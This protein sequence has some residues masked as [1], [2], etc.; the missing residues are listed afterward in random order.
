MTVKM[1]GKVNF[2]HNSYG[3]VIHPYTT[4]GEGVKIYHNVTIGRGNIWEDS[5]QLEGFE[6]KNYAVL[7]AGAKVI[8]S[9]GK[10]TIGEGTII[11]ANAVLTCS[12]GDYEIWAGVPAVRIGFR[13][14]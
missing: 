8:C 7:C 14:H 1:A 4:I 13:K 12:T 9:K 6:L 2:V 3:T 5:V 11:G 10:L